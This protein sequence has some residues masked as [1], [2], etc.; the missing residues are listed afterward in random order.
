MSA[1]Q[2]KDGSL[3]AFS[4]P[5]TQ[6]KV[7]NGETQ[8]ASGDAS[9]V[10]KGTRKEREKKDGNQSIPS[11]QAVQTVIYLPILDHDLSAVTSQVPCQLAQSLTQTRRQSNE[12]WIEHPAQGKDQGQAGSRKY[13]GSVGYQAD[14]KDTGVTI[15]HKAA[16]SATPKDTGRSGRYNKQQG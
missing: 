2:G 10:K 8:D 16:Q 4:Q 3:E 11:H 9:Q 14:K 5:T 15:G 13:N 1:S 12:D 7:S 6:K